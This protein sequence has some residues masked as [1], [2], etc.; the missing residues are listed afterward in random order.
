MKS[1]SILKKKHVLSTKNRMILMV[2]TN[3][4]KITMCHWLDIWANVSI[5]ESI[6]YLEYDSSNRWKNLDQPL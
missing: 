6:F 4:W 1:P 3:L 5:N 2:T